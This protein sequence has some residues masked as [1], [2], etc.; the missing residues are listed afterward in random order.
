MSKVIDSEGFYNQVNSSYDDISFKKVEYLRAIDFLIL[1]H[2]VKLEKICLVDIGSGNGRRLKKILKNISFEKL[3]LIEQSLGF[4]KI[5]KENFNPEEIFHGDV[6]NFQKKSGE[7]NIALCLWNVIA[8][9]DNPKTFLKA[10]HSLLDKNGTFIF[11]INNRF[12]IKEYGLKNVL[13][14]F[15]K[16]KIFSNSGLFILNTN[17]I[18]TKVYI[19]NLSEIKLLLKEAGF[20]IDFVKYVNYKTGVIEK[21]QYS[22]QMLLSCRKIK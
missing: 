19:Y 10:I 8:H 2:I 14:N 6:V 13:T 9:A 16:S 11:D 18:K 1:Q 22:G 21:N 7:F 17:G 12:N 4:V 3:L 15:I 5:L 20:A